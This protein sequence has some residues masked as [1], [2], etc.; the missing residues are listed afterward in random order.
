MEIAAARKLHGKNFVAYCERLMQIALNCTPNVS[1]E[2]VTRHVLNEVP[3]TI[4]DVIRQAR[5]QTVPE[6]MAEIHKFGPFIDLDPLKHLRP[7][8]LIYLMLLQLTLKL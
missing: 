2:I 3:S 1:E 8:H 6:L 5:P 4:R 7:L